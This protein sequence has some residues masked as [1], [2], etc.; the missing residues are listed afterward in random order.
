MDKAE[1]SQQLVKEFSEGRE[2]KSLI[3]H[4]AFKRAVDKLEG[5]YIKSIRSGNWFKK[6][7]REENCR[8]LQVLDDLVTILENEMTRGE[9]ALKRLEANN[10]NK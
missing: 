5:S 9:Q 3:E 4:P 10:A 1:R 8:R 7:A 2:A 6:R